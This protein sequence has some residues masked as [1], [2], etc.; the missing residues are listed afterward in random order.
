[1]NALLK[2]IYPSKGEDE[3]WWA[4][5]QRTIWGSSAAT[6]QDPPDGIDL[7]QQAAAAAAAAT[8]VAAVARTPR[9][10]RDFAGSHDLS[11]SPRS[12]LAAI[13]MAPVASTT[14]NTAHAVVVGAGIVGLC[15]ARDLASL[16]YD[17]VLLE[18]S[19]SVGGTWST[20]DYPGLRLH[21]PGCSYRCLSLAPAWTKQHSPEENYRPMRDEILQYCQELAKYADA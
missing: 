17:V 19:S 13:D 20:N 16:G 12:L 8:R 11:M 3:S 5:L 4:S 2:P 1:M 21:Q 18:R 7:Q 6:V 15:F 9:P 14:H 10:S